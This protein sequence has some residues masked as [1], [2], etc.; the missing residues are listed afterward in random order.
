MY[1]AYAIIWLPDTIDIIFLDDF[2]LN[3]DYFRL[4]SIAHRG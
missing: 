3:F 1:S 2:K 4:K